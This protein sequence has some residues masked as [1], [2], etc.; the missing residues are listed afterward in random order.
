TSEHL[1]AKR[2]FATLAT[3]QQNQFREIARDISEPDLHNW[4]GQFTTDATVAEKLRSQAPAGQITDDVRKTCEPQKGECFSPAL[5][6]KVSQL[7]VG[8]QQFE[9]VLEKRIINIP[10]VN[11]VSYNTHGDHL[12]IFRNNYTGIILG[13]SGDGQWHKQAGFI[14]NSRVEREPPFTTVI[15]SFIAHG[16][17][18]LTWDGFRTARIFAYN[19]DHSCTEQFSFVHESRIISADLSCDGHQ[20]VITCD[21]GSAK[22]HSLDDAG[23]WTLTADIADGRSWKACFSPDG[24][25]V[26]TRPVDPYACHLEAKIHRRNGEHGWTSET[27][28]D[29]NV[30]FVRFSPDGDQLL[31][32]GF[33]G[34]AKI[35]NL[36]KNDG[37]T[38]ES[39]KNSNNSYQ[40]IYFTASPDGRHIITINYHDLEIGNTTLKIFSRDD[41]GNWT[42]K[43]GHIPI[44]KDTDPGLSAQFSPDGCHVMA[45]VKDL[46]SVEFLS[47]D[48]HDNWIQTSIPL[49]GKTRKAFF[50]PDSSHAVVIIAGY[51]ASCCIYSYTAARGWIEKTDIRHNHERPQIKASFSADSRHVVSFCCRARNCSE[52]HAKIYGLDR[53]GD[54]RQRAIITHYGR[55]NSARFNADGSHLVTASADGTAIILGRYADGSWGV[56]TILKHTGQ[57][58]SAIFSANSRQVVTVSGKHTVEIWRL[59]GEDPVPPRLQADACMP[60]SPGCKRANKS[61]LQDD[62]D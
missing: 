24:S 60:P 13:F 56:K 38:L 35:L 59:Y 46:S 55:I 45:A 16:R 14:Y 39:I 1:L 7:M 32:F 49:R 19:A 48:K 44:S 5:F 34:V 18:L 62:S 12:V 28:S 29:P 9:P 20:V 4:L 41:S 31:L 11:N 10:E 42:G 50:S 25:Q 23:H 58:R 40:I 15:T 30:N 22:I 17:H 33:M 6:Y 3:H 27:I 2:W 37:N 61:G 26:L 57:V 52:Y 43:T 47:C 21:D 54:W 51:G 36:N 53:N 8:C